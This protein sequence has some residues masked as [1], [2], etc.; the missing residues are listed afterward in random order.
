MPSIAVVLDR[1]RR[2][3]GLDARLSGSGSACFVFPC[4]GPSVIQILKKE[5]DSAWGKFHWLVETELH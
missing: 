5:L 2:V 4:G 1:L 3:H